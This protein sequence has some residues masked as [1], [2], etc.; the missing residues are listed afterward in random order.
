MLMAI[1]A[2]EATPRARAQSG[3]FTG[4]TATAIGTIMY[5]E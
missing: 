3:N 5:I 4:V 2:T 1:R